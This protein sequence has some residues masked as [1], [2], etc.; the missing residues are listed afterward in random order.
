MLYCP[1]RSSGICRLS[2]VGFGW[3][4]AFGVVNAQGSID[5][6]TNGWVEIDNAGQIDPPWKAFELFY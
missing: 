2:A 5:H 4:R 6:E 1:V 3:D